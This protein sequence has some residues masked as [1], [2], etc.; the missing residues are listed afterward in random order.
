MDPANF[1]KADPYKTPKNIIPEWY[2]LLFYTILKSVP[3][4]KLL[5]LLL[6]FVP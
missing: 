5:A 2:F 6:C 4:K 3:Y 1:E